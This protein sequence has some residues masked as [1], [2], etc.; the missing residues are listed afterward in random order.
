MRTAALLAVLGCSL[1]T[2]AAEDLFRLS[3]GDPERREKTAPVALDAIT[4]TS[5][6]ELL[7]PEQLARRLEGVSLV[8]MGESHTTLEYHRAQLQLIRALRETGRPVLIGL[9]MFPYTEQRSLDYWNQGQV[10]E[11]GFV[12][13]SDWYTNWGYNWNY[14]RDIFLFARDHGIPMFAVNAPRSVVSEVRKKGFEGLSEEERSSLPERIDTDSAD[15]RRL[16]KIFL[17]GGE[18]NFHSQMTD[19]QLDGMFN[20]QCTWDAA[21]AFNSVRRLKEAGGENAIMVVLIGFGHVAY[22][23]GIQRQAALWYDGRMASVIPLE[24]EDEQGRRLEEAQASFAEYIWGLPTEE[25]PAFPEL[26]VSVRTSEETGETKI[27][28]VQSDSVAERAGL[29]QGDLLLAV[30][31]EPVKNRSML[32]E[33][34]AAKRWG[35][36]ATMTVRRDD[37]ELEL[38]AHFRRVLKKSPPETHPPV[39]E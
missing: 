25:F 34:I 28:H 16:F 2:A 32:N 1:G 12:E 24:I 39:G 31:G 4:D 26:G 6:G 15:H 23:L 38:V 7:S 3:I 33:W 13:L 21:M 5:S 36:S 11:K 20:A 17:T 19:E 30:D 9:E 10:T 27:I 22:D 14:Y 35:D 18:E 8:F 29:K 37:A